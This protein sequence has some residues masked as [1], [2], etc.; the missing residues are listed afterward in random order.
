MVNLNVNQGSGSQGSGIDVTA[1]VDQ[2]IYAESAQ[3]RAWQRQQLSLASD[4]VS[5]NA[6]NSS[7]SALRDKALSLTDLSGV[8]SSQAAVSSQ[9]GLLEATA[10][11]G[12]A[13]GVHSVVID[14][15]A[16]VSAYYTD[17]VASGGT[18]LAHGSFDLAVGSSTKT[19]TIDD[20]N[21]TLAKLS[22]YINAHDYGVQ[23]SVVTDANGARL[24]LASKTSGA[25]GDLAVSANTTSLTFRKS[26]TGVNAGFTVDG[27]PLS[28]TTN[29]VT[30]A[31]PG[32]TLN[33]LAANPGQT[34]TLTIS[35]DTAGI[36]QAITDFVS[37]YNSVVKS[38]NRQFT[39]DGSGNAGSLAG[40]SALRS[41]QTSLLSDI[42]Y[43]IKDNGGIVNLAS[44]GI[45][46]EN[47]GT[48]TVDNTKLDSALSGQFSN[49]EAFFQS[50]NSGSFGSNL[51]KDLAGLTSSTTGPL[52]LN[53]N[54]NSA[55]QKAIADQIDD[56]EDR[57]A[58][59][60]Q[61]LTRQYSEVDTLLRQFP[62]LMAQITGQLGSLPS[63]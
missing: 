24:A 39:T 25:P 27:V 38:I 40:N 22:A 51:S 4:A 56:F 12:A 53:L 21:D 2:I 17:P 23:A 13:V 1:L 45:E 61:A 60:R 10:K 47:D 62:L 54:E 16:T 42:T 32:V 63:N 48:L 35:H 20:T 41:L 33:L 6:L 50:A 55:S 49:V 31:I 26:I 29:T 15:L 8:F 52:S 9:P 46:M 59:R 11:A 18:V 34:I 28:S 14:H 3:E 5:L 19:I 7:V 44:L 57:L 58:L 37:A 30:T 36:K 43:S